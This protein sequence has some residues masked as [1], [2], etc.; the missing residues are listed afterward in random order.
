VSFSGFCKSFGLTSSPFNTY[1]TE[2]ELEYTQE[3]F[4]AQGEYDP[5]IDAF[6]SGKSIIITGERGSGKTAILEDF[7]RTLAGKK[8][9]N[10][11][12]ADFSEVGGEPKTEEVYRL[13]L[14]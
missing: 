13:F 8:K 3:L 2:Q 7:K 14:S 9:V 10:T 6:N 11:S 5:I 4:I 12:I 1:T